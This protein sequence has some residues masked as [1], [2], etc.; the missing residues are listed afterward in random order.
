MADLPRTALPSEE[1]VLLLRAA[2][3]DGPEAV[4][5]WGEWQR[6]VDFDDMDGASMRLMPLVSKN[7]RHMRVDHPLARRVH[8]IHRYSWSKNQLLLR[9]LAMVLDDLAAESV[10]VMVLKGVPLAL[11]YYSDP[12]LRPMS[13]FDLLVPT[14]AA[15][16]SV[17]F[18]LRTGWRVNEPVPVM[19][20]DGRVDT[21]ARPGVGF[22]SDEDE[23]DLHWHLLHDCC[24]DGAEESTW[25]HAATMEVQG[26]SVLAPDATDLLMHVCVH[27]AAYNPMPPI[28]WI[29]DAATILRTA[30]DRVDWDR[31][32][33]EADRRL[34][35]LVMRE[36]VRVLREIVDIPVPDWVD[37]R[38]RTARISRAE[39][40]E[41]S[42]RIIDQNYLRTVSGR[43]CQLRRQYRDLGPWARLTKL[44]VFMQKIW[45]VPTKR[46]LPGMLAFRVLPAYWKNIRRRT[47]KLESGTVGAEHH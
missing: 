10:D 47:S 33:A 8:G 6:R 40:R 45:S 42:R 11:C 12:G 3:L 15:D 28:R 5:A 38:L 22:A 39:R 21:G 18:L 23:C 27:G 2:L 30:G 16:R 35:M 17:E 29:A 4:S 43:W 25:R 7:M 34:L 13:D 20:P 36:A 41:Y 32:L 9:R 14:A 44:P 37:S 46:E 31:L 19:G 24:F 26:R 1:Q